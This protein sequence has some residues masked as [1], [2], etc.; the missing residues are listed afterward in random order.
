MG[1]ENVK[2][3]MYRYFLVKDNDFSNAKVV[4]VNSLR[5]ESII[6]NE[7]HNITEQ[8]LT[9]NRMMVL[10]NAL[11]DSNEELL[12]GIINQY[13]RVHPN[14]KIDEEGYTRVVLIGNQHNS[15]DFGYQV[16][17][18]N[19]NVKEQNVQRVVPII[20]DSDFV[21]NI[22]D[23][24]SQ[25]EFLIEP[26]RM[27][28]L[29]FPENCLK[30]YQ[31]DDLGK[32]QKDLYKLI[33][34]M[35]EKK[36]DSRI[37]HINPKE[38]KTIKINKKND[39][40]NIYTMLNSDVFAKV[41]SSDSSIFFN[42][43][44]VIAYHRRIDYTIYLSSK[45]KNTKKRYDMNTTIL[46]YRDKFSFSCKSIHEIRYDIEMYYQSMG[47]VTSTKPSVYE[48]DVYQLLMK[49]NEDHDTFYTIDDALNNADLYQEIFENP[50][51]KIGHNPID[52]NN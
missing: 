3:C 12:K 31:N 4:S 15:E 33:Y 16:Y 23:G 34:E 29:M 52:G 44:A 10:F 38:D 28:M 18:G 24:F 36:Y 20:Y 32:F 26:R 13:K 45:Y 40:K 17:E 42:L 21:H 49:Y 22:N 50:Q 30:T 39:K 14:S 27:L 2:N 7:Y 41:Y 8:D 48:E 37:K 5:L 51:R 1:K 11:F 35:L 19:K 25:K 47:K 9:L 6:I 46:T 43:L